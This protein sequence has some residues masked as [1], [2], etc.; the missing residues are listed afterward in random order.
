[1]TF[2]PLVKIVCICITIAGI[3]QENII[4][5]L[6]NDTYTFK[7]EMG[8]FNNRFTLL[9]KAERALGVGDTTIDAISVFPN[10]TK[11]QV[12]IISPN[13]TIESVTVYDMQGR[14]VA[15]KEE[16]STSMNLD[17]TNMQS[18]V[19]FIKIT[20]QKGTIT[21]RIVKN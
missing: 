17:I 11:G 13:A 12:T 21:K 19:Y 5:N 20:T 2:K 16:M 14:V 4:T 9:F 3:G 6:E 1:M 15:S 8:V 7:S 10:P 18:S